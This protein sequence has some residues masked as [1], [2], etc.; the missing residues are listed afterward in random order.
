MLGKKI[1]NLRKKEGLSQEDLGNKLYVSR[2][3]ISKWELGESAPD[4]NTAKEIAKVF[5]I[6]LD[7]LVDNDIRDILESKITNTERLASMIMKILKFSGI[8]LI[9]FIVGLIIWNIKSSTYAWF[10]GQ[11][12]INCKVGE[13]H[14]Y[15][16]IDVEIIE[17]KLKMFKTVEIEESNK[18]INIVR[19]GGNA[20]LSD[21]IDITK[22]EYTYQ[23]FDA[24]N[25]Y[26][27]KHDGI[28][29]YVDN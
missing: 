29:D 25:A 15:Y 22:Y 21:I 19:L 1:V 14:Y 5:N 20:Y 18:I 3:T 24:V 13:D 27:D 17:N 4:I 11:D 23:L 8:M 16:K 28:C 9:I 2:Q 10:I 12:V 26:V 6:S 7:E